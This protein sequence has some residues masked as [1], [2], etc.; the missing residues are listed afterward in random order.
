M[1]RPEQAEAADHTS[2]Q[3]E[4]ASA[5]QRLCYEHMCQDTCNRQ[6]HEC[7]TSTV[8]KCQDI[9]D[10][11]RQTGIY[12][13]RPT[14]IMPSLTFQFIQGSPKMKGSKFHSFTTL[15]NNQI[16]ADIQ[17]S[18]TGK[19]SSKFATELSKIAPHLKCFATLL[20]EISTLKIVVLKKFHQNTYEPLEISTFD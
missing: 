12:C 11:Q 13:Q 6:W 2:H 8:V 9:S 10:R 3:E 18:F 4:V 17:H 14:L 19:L 1:N 16:M 20:C 15:L 5:G 7:Q